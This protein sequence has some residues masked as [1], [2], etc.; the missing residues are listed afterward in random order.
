MS[1]C[2]GCNMTPVL[3]NNFKLTL[4]QKP[5]LQNIVHP[6]DT[7]NTKLTPIDSKINTQFTNNGKFLKYTR[8]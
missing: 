2:G 7:N 5:K 1:H 6:F 4:Q 8:K 3:L